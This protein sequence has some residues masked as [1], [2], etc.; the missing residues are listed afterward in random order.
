[1]KPICKVQPGASVGRQRRRK[2]ACACAAGL[3]KRSATASSPAPD[4]STICGGRAH[5]Q[6]G[7]SPPSGDSRRS[8]LAGSASESGSASFRTAWAPPPSSF[9]Q[10]TNR[11]CAASPSFRIRQP[12]PPPHLD[13]LVAGTGRHAPPVE[14]ERDIMDEVLMVRRDA[15]R[16]KHSSRRV[17]AFS[18]GSSHLRRGPRTRRRFTCFTRVPAG[19]WPRPSSVT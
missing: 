18:V 1:M 13:A 7:A 3:R 15:A 2:C 12:P 11:A 10:R 8:A 14:V 9:A 17:P 6:G 16:H 19:A 4:D 5:G